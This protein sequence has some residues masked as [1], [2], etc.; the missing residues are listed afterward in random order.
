MVDAGVLQEDDR[1]EL[2]DGVLVDVS[3]PGVAHSS[4]VTWLNRHFAS[5]VG[6]HDVRVQDL[7]LVEGGFVMPDL[8]LTEQLPRDRHPTTA[9]LVVEVAVTTHGHDAWKADRYARAGVEE[10]WIVDPP[11]RSLT[12]HRGPSASGY[13]EITRHTDGDVVP[14]SVGAPD[15]DVSALLGPAD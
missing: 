11:G 15:V 10:Y 12:V 8:M 7:L 13:R 1:V 5:V 14:T 6:E 3:P 4:T 2:I 9:A